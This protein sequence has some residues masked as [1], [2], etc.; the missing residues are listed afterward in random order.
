MRLYRVYVYVSLFLVLC[1]LHLSGSY[2]LSVLFCLCLVSSMFLIQ[3]GIPLSALFWNLT[4]SVLTEGS[5]MVLMY[6]GPL[7]SYSTVLWSSVLWL[8]SSFSPSF[9]LAPQN[10]SSQTLTPG[11]SSSTPW[12]SSW[13]AL[14]PWNFSSQTP[15]PILSG[16]DEYLGLRQ[17]SFH[18]VI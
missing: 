9:N 11:D 6:S 10:S 16:F 14:S 13:Q 12:N 2:F 8:H 7:Y 18:T 3:F 4:M 17:H 15:Q 5:W 1:D